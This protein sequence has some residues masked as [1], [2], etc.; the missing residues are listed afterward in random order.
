[1]PTLESIEVV[2]VRTFVDEGGDLTFSDPM[3]QDV[4]HNYLYGQASNLMMVPSDCDNRDERFGWTG[5]S[6]RC[7]SLQQPTTPS[8]R[9]VGLATTY[10]AL[11][12]L[13]LYDVQP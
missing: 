8:N 6:V 11:L 7:S 1:V 10:G 4:H 13:D 2:V 3:L 5:D 12:S 9:L